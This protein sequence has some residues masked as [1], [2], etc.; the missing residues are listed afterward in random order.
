MIVGPVK[1]IQLYLYI[2]CLQ[3]TANIEDSQEVK[4]CI[5][6]F[7]VS[8]LQEIMECRNLANL[9]SN[10]TVIHFTIPEIK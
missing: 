9:L 3:F 4:M 7:T 6:A 2:K 5:N 1:Q 10:L 8:F